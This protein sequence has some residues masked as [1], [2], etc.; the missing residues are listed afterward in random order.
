M[1]KRRPLRFPW[2]GS[3]SVSASKQGLPL[4]LGQEGRKKPERNVLR[5]W[6]FVYF[7][8]KHC[9]EVKEHHLFYE[10]VIAANRPITQTTTLSMKAMLYKYLSPTSQRNY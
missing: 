3:L 7:V 10:Q 4:I 8:G 1:F 2:E 9:S 5:L 6:F